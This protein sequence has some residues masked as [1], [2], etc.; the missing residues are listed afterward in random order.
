MN[1]DIILVN[2]KKRSYQI[3]KSLIAIMLAFVFSMPAIRA[4]NIPYHSDPKARITAPNPSLVPAIRFLTSNNFPPFNFSNEIGELSG[5]NIDLAKEICLFLDI[6]C[7][8]QAWPWDQVAD[9][10]SSNQGDALIA[11]LAINE[12]NAKY[13][14]FSD[15]YLMFPARFITLKDKIDDFGKTPLLEQIIAVRKNSNHEKFLLHYFPKLKTISYENEIEALN[16]LLAGKSSAFF[17]DAMR[18]SFW[19]NENPNC[20]AFASN[21]YFNSNYFGQGLAITFPAGRGEVRN[22]VNYAL[23]QLKKNGKYD[24]LYLR[25]FPISFY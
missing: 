25:W 13:F 11:G 2:R 21:A 14:D 10:L 9:A 22:V 12:E 7:T 15:I 23:A 5:F 8:I 6:V 24:E 17:G 4:Q 19:L 3:F 16:A 1:V 20:C 18:I